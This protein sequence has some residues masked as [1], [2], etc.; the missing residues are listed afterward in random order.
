MHCIV[1]VMRDALCD[2]DVADAPS[3]LGL[4]SPNLLRLYNFLGCSD[5]NSNKGEAPQ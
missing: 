5:M 2:L 4:P 1:I 3:E